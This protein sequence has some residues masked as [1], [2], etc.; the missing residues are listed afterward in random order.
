M[1]TFLGSELKLYVLNKLLTFLEDP[2]K[3]HFSHNTK[4]YSR[5]SSLSTVTSVKSQWY[6]DSVNGNYDLSPDRLSDYRFTDALRSQSM[7]LIVHCLA[8]VRRDE[9]HFLCSYIIWPW[10]EWAKHVKKVNIQTSLFPVDPKWNDYKNAWNRRDQ[11]INCR[12]LARLYVCM[13]LP[14]KIHWGDISTS[15]SLKLAS[16]LRTL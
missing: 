12:G 8:R 11:R 13:D 16:L 4:L 1:R 2:R 3:Y 7:S 10:T 14:I 9:G 6:R 5:V 15:K